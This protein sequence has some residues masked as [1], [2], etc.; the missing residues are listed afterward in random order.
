[1]ENRDDSNEM[2]LFFSTVNF[3]HQGNVI[4]KF[5]IYLNEHIISEDNFKTMLIFFFTLDMY[6]KNTGLIQL[7]EYSDTESINSSIMCK[8][9]SIYRKSFYNRIS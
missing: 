8:Q 1:M 2:L 4:F 7:L 3:F 9:K 6:I 5:D